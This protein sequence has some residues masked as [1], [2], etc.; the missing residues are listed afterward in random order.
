MIVR[1]AEQLVLV[2]DPVHRMG[3]V[4]DDQ[5]AAIER[6]VGGGKPRDWHLAWDDF[7]VEGEPR[8]P[9]A[10]VC[11]QCSCQRR[12]AVQGRLRWLDHRRRCRCA[13]RQRSAGGRT[14]P[15]G[16]ANGVQHRRAAA[17]AKSSSHEIRPHGRR[18]HC[19][20]RQHGHR[21]RN[22]ARGNSAL[23]I[24]VRHLV[25][26]SGRTEQSAQPSRGAAT[27][28]GVVGKYRACGCFFRAG[29]GYGC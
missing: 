16:R 11:D 24:V 2:L 7:S 26:R 17:R 25:N 19:I 6:G 4:A 21:V 29:F 9:L 1:F 28:W 14:L 10:A 27:S 22:A 8:P 20:E 5:Y 23:A 3:A 12:R 15:V 13:G 18:T